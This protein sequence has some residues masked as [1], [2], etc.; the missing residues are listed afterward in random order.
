MFHV[1][2]VMLTKLV[3]QKAAVIS[4]L[5]SPKP[6]KHKSAVTMATRMDNRKTFLNRRLSF[7]SRIT[8]ACYSPSQSQM[9]QCTEKLQNSKVQTLLNLEST[10]NI[11]GHGSTISK[12]P[13]KCDLNR[14]KYKWEI[15]TTNGGLK[16][17][18]TKNIVYTC[19]I[20]INFN[21]YNR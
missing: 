19:W 3:K 11:K 12:R 21:K 10:I 16:K 1:Q 17:S 18:K 7:K 15:S 6:R 2:T 14:K 5:C 4:L 20:P 8:I 9:V 13:H